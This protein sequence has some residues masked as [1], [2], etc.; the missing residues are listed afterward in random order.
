MPM[1]RYILRYRG[2][3]PIPAEDAERI[4]GLD[5]VS[6]IDSTSRMLLVEAPGG[7]L[8]QLVASMPEW[9]LSEERTISPPDP[10]PKLRET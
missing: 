6:V 10:R 7:E 5:G 2:E 9:V 3:G 8:K 4:R 1:G